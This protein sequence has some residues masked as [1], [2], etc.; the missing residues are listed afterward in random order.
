LETIKLLVDK[1]HESEY[2]NKHTE[3]HPECFPI[4]NSRDSEV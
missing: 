3:K 4:E 1:Y 2:C